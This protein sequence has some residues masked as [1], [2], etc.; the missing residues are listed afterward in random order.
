MS[1]AIT[2]SEALPEPCG[3]HESRLRPPRAGH[4]HPSEVAFRGH[5]VSGG[6]QQHHGDGYL[7]RLPA[8]AAGLRDALNAANT[9]ATTAHELVD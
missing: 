2:Y 9:G 1:Q 6:L 4:H 8:N 5:D 7:L 3:H